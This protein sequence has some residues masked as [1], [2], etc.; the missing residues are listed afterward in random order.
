MEIRYPLIAVCKVIPTV[1]RSRLLKCN[2]P[3]IHLRLTIQY[4]SVKKFCDNI[5]LGKPVQNLHAHLSKNIYRICLLRRDFSQ[6]DIADVTGADFSIF[7]GLGDFRM[8]YNKLRSVRN[9]YSASM[10]IV[11]CYL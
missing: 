5:S 4:I 2:F 1:T 8:T 11:S 9:H 3:K 6:Y 7:T 10:T